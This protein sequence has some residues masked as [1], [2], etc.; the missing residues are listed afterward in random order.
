MAEYG[1]VKVM[2]RECPQDWKNSVFLEPLRCWRN[3]E[4]V[5]VLVAWW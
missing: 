3:F 4:P 1:R 2:A 5:A